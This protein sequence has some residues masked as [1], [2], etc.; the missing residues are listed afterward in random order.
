MDFALNAE[1]KLLQSTL[2]DFAARELLPAY[3]GRDQDQDLP[4]A[5]VRQLG[6]MGLLAPMVEPRFGGQGLDYVSLGLAHEEIARADFNAAYVLLLSALVGAIVA[7]RGDDSQRAALLPPICRGE[8]IAALAVTEPGAG[9]D[10]AHARLLARR[11]GDAYLLDGEKSSISFA[12]S[13]IP[14]S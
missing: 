9:S 2:R 12:T 6:E 4:R 11:E 1:Q 13:P 7:A 3:A 5:L 8:V 14:R 10:A